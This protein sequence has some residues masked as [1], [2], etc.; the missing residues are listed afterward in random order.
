MV[1]VENKIV[2]IINMTDVHDNVGVFI[3][4]FVSASN[5]LKIGENKIQHGKGKYFIS[6]KATVMSWGYHKYIYP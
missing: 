1:M 6:V 3:D 4:A 5:N 2:R